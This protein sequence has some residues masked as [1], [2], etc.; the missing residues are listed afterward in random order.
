MVIG[1]KRVFSGAGVLFG[2]QA[3]PCAEL[4][5]APELPE[6][7]H[8]AITL[9]LGG[10]LDLFVL[11]LMGGQAQVAP[12]QV[13]IQLLPLG[14]HTGDA[15]ERL[16]RPTRRMLMIRRRQ[17]AGGVARARRCGCPRRGLRS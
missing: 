3:E 4:C 1:D 15:H 7:A 5:A 8:G 10:T 11:S 2:N 13:H 17:V 12:V 14:L 6:V 9:Q 16:A